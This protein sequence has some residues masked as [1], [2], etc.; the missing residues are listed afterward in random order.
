MGYT[1]KGINARCS[2]CNRVSSP[3]IATNIGD[4]TD[5]PFVADPKNPLFY[6]CQDCKESHEELIHEY[7]LEDLL[8]NNDPYGFEED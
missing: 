3:D 1:P 6:I 5:R 4:Y 7:E 8:E 2:I